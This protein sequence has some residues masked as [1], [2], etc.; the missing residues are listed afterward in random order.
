[1][2]DPTDDLVTIAVACEMIGGKA[3]P[4]VPATLY[5]GIKTGKFPAP[6]KLGPGTSR[7]RRSEILDCIE[8]AAAARE[9]A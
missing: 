2:T 5:R 3:T 4:I 9:V 7:W 8:R 6:L 1:M